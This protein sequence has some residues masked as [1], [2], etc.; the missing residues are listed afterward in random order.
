MFPPKQHFFIN[1]FINQV[2]IFRNIHQ[3]MYCWFLIKWNTG[4]PC[5]KPEKLFIGF[6]PYI[7]LHNK[8]PITLHCMFKNENHLR[9]IENILLHR[10]AKTIHACYSIWNST[11][12][13]RNTTQRADRFLA[14]YDSRYVNQAT[15]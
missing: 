6:I 11:E 10:S 12:W 13:R 3:Q 9:Q 4:K 2:P 1:F 15:Q 5:S 14:N 7:G 8:T